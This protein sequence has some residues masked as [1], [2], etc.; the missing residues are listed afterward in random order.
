MTVGVSI[1]EFAKLDGCNEK[2]VRRGIEQGKLKALEDG[3][4]DP[5][6]VG[7]PWRRTN[8][9]PAEKA[10]AKPAHPVRRQKQLAVSASSAPVPDS[11]VIMP[12]GEMMDSAAAAAAVKEL[13]SEDFPL[14]SLADAEKMKEIYL[15]RLRQLEY[16]QKSG[17]VVAVEDVAAAVGKKF[18]AVRSRLLSIPAE[19]AAKIHRLKSPAEVQD[20]LQEVITRALEELMRGDTGGL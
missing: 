6:L 8:R 5:S 9:H 17:R 20:A 19:Q 1:R 10:S 18:A 7:S 2:L 3:K 14:L 15:A 12:D 13:V 16:D 4:V 11:A